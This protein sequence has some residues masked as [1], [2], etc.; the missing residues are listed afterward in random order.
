MDGMGRIMEQVVNGQERGKRTTITH[1]V[2]PTAAGSSMR[3]ELMG[4]AWVTCR[5]LEVE[6]DHNWMT[7]EI[8]QS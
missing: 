6:V 7:M 1:A 8:G 4:A 2:V 3:R 5:I